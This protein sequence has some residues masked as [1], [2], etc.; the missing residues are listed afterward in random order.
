MLVAVTLA[1]SWSQHYLMTEGALA[2]PEVAA[3]AAE[4][5]TVEPVEAWL[6]S[7][8]V[9]RVFEEFAAWEAER[10][11]DRF[12]AVPLAGPT[13]EAFLRSARLNPA[14]QLPL[15]VRRLPGSAPAEA[16][17]AA[18][19][20]SPFLVDTPPWV[21]DVVATPPGTTVTA[22][23]VLATFADEPDWGLD[24]ELWGRSEYGYGEQPYGNPAGETSKAPFHMLFA[25]ENLLVRL[26][27]P[28]VLD[29]MPLDR[30]ELFTR[31]SRQAFAEGHSYWGWRLAA[32]ATHYVQDL[33][34][35]YHSKAIPS[36]GFG[37]YLAYAVSK[38]Q[39]RLKREATTL[40]G[41]RHFL[42][43][44]YV[45]YATQQSHTEDVP[46]YDTLAAYLGEGPATWRVNN[47]EGLLDRVT[48]RA[49]RHARRIDRTLERTF[50]EKW[51]SDPALDLSTS[52]D[53]SIVTEMKGMD[54][55]QGEKLLAESGVDFE[56]TGIAT[57]T[58]MAL[59]RP[60]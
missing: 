45:A 44:D 42:Y 12:K 20:V 26:F 38:E 2:H 13:R 16:P 3:L 54:P 33:C 5:V 43:E 52:P 51:T 49:S 53:Y 60:R 47:A 55:R 46:T 32:W 7:D 15:V 11:S 22:G 35:P 58:L 8:G 37:Y 28:E 34:Q 57:R 25:H 56:A 27:A 40:S 29:G 21:V 50:G 59:V 24:H 19:E 9:A 30:V 48:R 4:M 10:R 14:T 18:R 23:Q 17:V 36:V 31:L 39:D 6:G 1:W 41:N